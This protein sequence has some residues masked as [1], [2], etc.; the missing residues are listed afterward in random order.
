MVEDTAIGSLV[1]LDFD[2]ILKF[3]PE[4]KRFDCRLTY[5]TVGTPVDSSEMNISIWNLI[6][7][8][9]F[10]N[11]HVHDGFVLLHGT[12]TMAYTASALS[13][14]LEGLQKPV[15]MT[16]SQLPL[17]RLRT[18]GKE[19]LISSIEIAVSCS[20]GRHALHEVAVFFGSKLMR[21]NRTHK[22]STEY[23]D[24]IVSD[25]YS[26][27]ADAGVNIM[28]K[29]AHFFKNLETT[30][31]FRPFLEKRIL[32]VRIFPGIKPELFFPLLPDLDGLLLESYGSGNIP[33][34]QDL[35]H[36][37]TAAKERGIFVANVSQCNKG[38]VEHGRYKT[39]EFLRRNAVSGAADMTSE[40]ALAKMTYLLS[41]EMETAEREKLFMTSLRGELTTFSTLS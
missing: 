9:L 21:G 39:G 36:L 35:F 4:L 10:E 25:N 6:G 27:L 18:D 1:P 12:D 29:P 11:Y 20:S 24:G 17:G 34:N 2:N 19:N 16:G 13:F 41:L 15:I 38:F 26:E 32:V 40:A 37:I 3:I 23:F 31:T 33:G 30:L 28:Y 14:M 5:K 7:R 8:T 22:Y